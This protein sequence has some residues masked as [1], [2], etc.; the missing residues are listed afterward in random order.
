[1]EPITTNIF[2]L[3]GKPG[4]GRDTL[5]SGILKDDNFLDEFNI[6]KL[7]C[8]TTRPIKPGEI[9]GYHY[10]FFTKEEYELIEPTEFIEA[11]SYDNIYINDIY[12][13]FTLK[14]YIVYGNNYITKVSTFQYSEF[15]KWALLSQLEN[16][17]HRINIY[18]VMIETPIYERVNRMILKSKSEE[19][20]YRMC[21][22]LLTE[23]F[24]FKTVLEQNP[25]VVDPLNQDSCIIDN[26]ETGKESIS[27][28]IDLLELFI[29]RKIYSQG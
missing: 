26:S 27:N 3:L 25:E 20:I 9:N 5:L 28:A 14:K 15:K 22:K 6:K 7:V 8:G 29:R 21:S 1:M 13:Y 11:R 23:Q 19:D 16:S 12:W 4:S 24:E 2:C 18:P 10:H 17:M